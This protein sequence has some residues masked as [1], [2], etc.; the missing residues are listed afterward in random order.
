MK[1]RVIFIVSLA[2][3]I[4]LSAC[5]YD[6]EV[7]ET[8]NNEEQANTLTLSWPVDIG[9]VNPHLYTPN[10]MFAQ[11]MLY[12]PLVVYNNDGTLSPGLAESWDIASDG[13]TY[14]LHLREGVQYSD[15]SLL[16]A[17]NV[18]RN[19]DTVI[20]NSEA[21][22]WLEVVTVIE[23]VEV[24]DELTVNIHLKEAYYP[25]LQELSLIRPLRMLGDAGFPESGNTAD[26]IKAPIG[27]GPWILTA[28]EQDQYAEFTRNENY[29]GKKPSIQKVVVKIIADSQS[30]IMALEKGE[31]DLIFG[32]AQLAPTEF[33]TLQQN[34]NYITQVSEPLSTRII[35]MNTTYGVTK[36]KEVRLALQ[37]AL[38]RQT[39]IEHVLNGL[40]QE[41]YSL[42]APGFPYSDIEINEYEFDL[43]KSA[44][45]LDKAGWIVDEKTGV[46]VKDGKSLTI[47]I[48]YNSDDQVHKAIYEYLQ[49]TWKEIGIDVQLIGEESQILYGRSKAGEYNLIMNDS[50]GAPYDPHMYLR[51][52]TG[53]KQ[54][55]FYAKEGTESNEQLTRDI[56]RVIRSTDEAE[57]EALYESIIQTIHE[58]AI[59]MPISY[60]QNYLVANDVFEAITFSPQQYEVPINLYEM[61]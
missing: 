50:W 54:L 47:T 9:E 30:R 1:S 45:I 43:D 38:D 20:E 5:S 8:K 19:F 10:E 15:G 55:G 28:Y 4:V 12:D 24:V 22:S 33:T 37:H 58:E 34:A 41:A 3:M 61:K 27:T 14:T 21:H 17:D 39:I 53:E 31:I 49:G 52:M 40:E 13:K 18:K 26:G 60:R 51:T 32:S 35:S 46:R 59:L 7:R 56:L 48:P 36:Y 44:A 23:E 2:V 11:A 6:G 29:W 42:F 16:T 57:R 25:F